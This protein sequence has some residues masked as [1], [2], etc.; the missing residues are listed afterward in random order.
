[1]KHYILVEFEEEVVCNEFLSD[2]LNYDYD[3][4]GSRYDKLL[5]IE[6]NP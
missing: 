5:N 1:M 2:K 3:Y 6:R 4:C